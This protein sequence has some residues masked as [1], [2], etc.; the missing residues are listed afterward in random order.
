MCFI[1]LTHICSQKGDVLSGVKLLILLTL[2]IVSAHA[3]Q[4]FSPF[5]SEQY[6][7]HQVQILNHG[8]FS[9]KKRLDMIEGAQNTIEM[10][11]FIFRHDKAGRLILRS[12]VQKAS[13][14]VKVRVLFDKFLVKKTMNKYL[15]AHLKNAGIEVRFFNTLP[16]IFFNRAQYRNHRK[17]LIVDD[18]K[19]II[20]GRNIGNEYFDMDENYNF[21]DR[22]IFVDG[23]IAKT[24][25]QSFDVFW[26]SE[27]TKTIDPAKRPEMSRFHHKNEHQQLF[28]YRSRLRSYEKNMAKEHEFLYSSEKTSLMME[29]E[30]FWA[31]E[32]FNKRSLNDEFVCDDIGY[33]S[34][35]PSVGR[36]KTDNARVLKYRVF[37]LIKNAKDN[38]LIESPYFIMDKDMKKNIKV[39]LGKGTEVKVLTNGLYST[40]AVYVG[41]RMYDLV[42]SWLKLG[43]DLFLIKG[44]SVKNYPVFRSIFK[45]NRWGTHAKTII[46]DD[47]T[48]VIGTYNIDPRSNNYNMEHAIVCRNNPA[49]AQALKDSVY[50]RIEDSSRHMTDEETFEKLK[51]EKVSTGKMFLYYLVKIPSIIF[52]HLL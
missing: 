37:D 3:E 5:V 29:L 13:E 40:D 2:F 42:R 24:V 7:P 32:E 39:A 4:A 44:S 41:S 11:Y 21:I 47:E 26:K 19:V 46:V 1:D 10:E 25:R 17:T 27:F 31:G 35:M 20:G 36:K 12:L 23:P 28:Q 52:N 14:G 43:L 18:E 15:L 48:S 30:N 6:T 51:F 33:Y 34:D 9:L 49:M 45:K 22:D 8:S 38:V 50:V 16:N